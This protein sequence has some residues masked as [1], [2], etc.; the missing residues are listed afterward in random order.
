MVSCRNEGE[1]LKTNDEARRSI[2]AALHK[3]VVHFC[4]G[5]S[6]SPNCATEGFVDHGR[7]AWEVWAERLVK[8]ATDGTAHAGSTRS[9]PR[10]FGDTTW[11]GETDR[12]TRDD[13]EVAAAKAAPP[14]APRRGLQ[15]AGTG[16]ITTR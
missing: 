3:F 9:G 7:E 5:I 1:E 10:H 2:T 8:T 14:R 13:S 12:Y 15:G 6:L 11:T 16:G 4:V